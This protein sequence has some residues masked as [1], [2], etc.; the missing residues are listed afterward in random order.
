LGGPYIWKGVPEQW[1][2]LCRNMI[3]QGRDTHYFAQAN[4]VTALTFTGAG[5]DAIAASENLVAAADATDN[6]MV[7]CYTLVAYGYARRDADPAAAYESF[8]RGL[9]IARDSGNRQIESHLAGNVS[10][11]SGSHGNAV[12]ALDNLGLAIRNHYDS[13]SFSLMLSPLVILAATLDRL[14]HNEAAATISGFTATPYTRASYIEMNILITNLRELLG[15]DTYEALARTGKAMAPTA[16]ATYAFEQI[17]L[18]RA[19]LLHTDESP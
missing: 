14:G 8:Q 10:I 15:D 2:E 19:N 11:V 1:L 5:D 17:D 9:T 3:A 13:G 6:P 7:I 16:M 18:A 4:L 12:D